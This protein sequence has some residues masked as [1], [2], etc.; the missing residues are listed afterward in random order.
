MSIATARKRL[1]AHESKTAALKAAHRLLISD[2]AAA[3]T[4]QAVAQKI[5]RTHANLLH[6]FGSAAGLQRALAERIAE[7]VAKTIA[8]A[9]ASRRRGEASPRDVVNAL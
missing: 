8:A 3:V 9:V 5:G 6:H 2:G 7:D 1:D 4:L